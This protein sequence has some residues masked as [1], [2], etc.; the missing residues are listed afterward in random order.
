[1]IRSIAY[2]PSAAFCLHVAEH[3]DRATLTAQ[4]D[5][6]DTAD[7]LTAPQHASTVLRLF[8]CTPGQ[9]SRSVNGNDSDY[10]V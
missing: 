2:R 8:S 9:T 7:W 3:F 10:R 4:V 5:G 1:M 6:V